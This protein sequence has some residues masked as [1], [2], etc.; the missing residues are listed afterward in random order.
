MTKTGQDL[1]LIK[2][3]C[4]YTLSKV[5]VQTINPWAKKHRGVQAATAGKQWLHVTLMESCC[6]FKIIDYFPSLLLSLHSLQL[7]GTPYPPYMQYIRHKLQMKPVLNLQ[8]AFHFIHHSLRVCLFKFLLLHI[9]LVFQV[10]IAP[11]K[12]VIAFSLSEPDNQ[13]LMEIFS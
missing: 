12:M 13:H 3:I 7:S 5:R 10:S 11:P 8:N 4:R 1:L 9:K 2:R 6:D